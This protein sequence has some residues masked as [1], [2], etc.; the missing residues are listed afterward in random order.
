MPEKTYCGTKQVL[1]QGYDRFALPMQCLRK[2]YGACLYANRRGTGQRR[3]Q[4]FNHTSN[5]IFF[6]LLL[7]FTFVLMFYIVNKFLFEP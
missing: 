2:G 6:V 3:E 1:P 7:L 5:R 4:S